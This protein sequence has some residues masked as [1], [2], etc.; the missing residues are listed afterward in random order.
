MHSAARWFYGTMECSWPT[1]LHYLLN[2]QFTA[3]GQAS[4]NPTGRN[5][6][7]E[8]HVY[9]APRSILYS[10]G[11]RCPVPSELVFRPEAFSNVGA[12]RFVG[13]GRDVYA[14]NLPRRSEAD[15]D[16]L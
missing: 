14:C 9:A 13:R 16:Q 2:E 12:D 7:R 10:F 3:S 5:S 1:V 8:Y 11:D 6:V 4:Q 15:D